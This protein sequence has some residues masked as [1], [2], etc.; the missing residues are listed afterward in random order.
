MQV[1][2]TPIELD[3]ATA[4]IRSRTLFGRI[5]DKVRDRLIRQRVTELL[6]RRALRKR[7]SFCMEIIY[8]KNERSELSRLCDLYDSDKGELSQNGHSYPWPSHSYADFYEMLFNANREAVGL[9]VECGI[10]TSCMGANYKPGA[11]LR[12]WS[13]YFPQADIIGLDIDRSVLFSEDR[14]STYYCDQ[15]DARSIED[16][17]KA[18]HLSA[19]SVDIIVDDGL[20]TFDAGKCFFENAI[21]LLKRDGTYVVEDVGRRDRKAFAEYFAGRQDEF[22]VQFVNLHRP[23]LSLW[24]NSLVV[25]R[26]KQ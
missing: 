3:S 6:D 1:L 21:D 10:G 16:F 8:P 7:N 22:F 19:S 13:D 18:A 26:K 9:I 20:H 4:T 11:S 24:D 25:V 23:D 12:V 15:T 5:E 2:K 14:I 17:R